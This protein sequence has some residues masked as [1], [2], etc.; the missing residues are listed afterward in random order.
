MKNIIIPIQV[1]KREFHSKLL[2]TYA[3][4]NN[5][6]KKTSVFLGNYKKLQNT[7]YK[8]RKEN[9]V[10]LMNGV[11]TYPSFYKKINEL[12]GTIHLLEEEGNI[13]TI[14]TEKKLNEAKKIYS[15]LRYI[16]KVY[17]WSD[18]HKNR[19]L[20][21]NK[22]FNFKIKVTGNPRFDISKEKFLKKK[23]K[24]YVLVNT[25]FASVN[26]IVNLKSERKYSDFFDRGYQELNLQKEKEEGYA[27]RTYS[28]EEK[29]YNSFMSDI[30]KLASKKKE[31]SFLLR[32]H[33]A[34]N[35]NTYKQMFKNFKNVKVDETISIQEALEQAFL[36]IHPGCTT[37]IEAYLAGIGSICHVPFLNDNNIQ[38]LPYRLSFK[39]TKFED[40]ET[41]LDEILHNGKQ[42]FS[43]TEEIK[44]YIDNV[45]YF[46]FSK[47]AKNLLDYE[48]KYNNNFFNRL[49]YKFLDQKN[50]V[51]SLILEFFKKIFSKQYRDLKSEQIIRE[52]LKIPTLT[53]NEIMDYL[54]HLNKIFNTNY[55]YNI[56]KENDQVFQIGLKK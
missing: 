13:F 54:Q 30:K 25:L 18:S 53:R 38:V 7:I 15:Y 35:P 34:E 51:S 42:D 31:V 52:K 50:L 6:D 27:I 19:W 16:E 22:D 12:N 44:K 1:K 28:E 17:A 24:K 32:P 4:L 2:I 20:K 3:L 41:L 9:F 23:E 55:Q 37:A 36:V 39:S 8:C 56:T 47:I 49:K 14:N 46:S 29:L 40:L 10:Y 43:K 48:L 26:A 21:Y 11:N 33:P 5:K 45:E